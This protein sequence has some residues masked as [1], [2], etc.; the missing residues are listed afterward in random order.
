MPRLTRLWLALPLIVLAGCNAAPVPTASPSPVSSTPPS[1]LDPSPSPI[2][3]TSPSASPQP[4]PSPI[5]SVS[6]SPSVPSPAGAV[7]VTFRVA[8]REEFKALVTDPVNVAIVRDL[9]AGR[10][11]P[12]I[13][14]GKIVYQTGVN[15]G[16]HWSMDPTD[17]E[18]ADSTTEVCDGLPSDVENHAITS[19]RYCPWSAKVIAIDPA[20]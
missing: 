14:N 5:P 1:I 11:A 20:P 12:A 7:I 10:E 18:F 3:V 4:S 17:I 13:P 15:T 2:P 16:Y 19:P 6:P 9:L 8:D